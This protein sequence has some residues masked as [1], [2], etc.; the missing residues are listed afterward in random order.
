M[1]DELP[2]THIIVGR[3]QC[4]LFGVTSFAGIMTLRNQ[5]ISASV[6][7]LLICFAHLID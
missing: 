1:G 5:I 2:P 3:W 7:S 6:V 4:F